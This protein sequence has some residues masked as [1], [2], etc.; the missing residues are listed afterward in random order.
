MTS[1]ITIQSQCPE[2]HH[3][4]V[5]SLDNWNPAGGTGGQQQTL[6]MD[7]CKIIATIPSGQQKEVTL[8]G[9]QMLFFSEERRDQQQQRGQQ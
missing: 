9:N 8:S 7:K 3:L 1:K 2:T 5:R 6:A 4:L